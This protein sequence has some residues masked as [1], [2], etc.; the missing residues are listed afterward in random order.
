MLARLRRRLSLPFRA[1][2]IAAELQEALA[3][4]RSRYDVLQAALT[5]VNTYFVPLLF[6]LVYILIAWIWKKIKST[7]DSRQG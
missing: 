1:G 5:D 6:I 2:E 3:S 4:L 7:R